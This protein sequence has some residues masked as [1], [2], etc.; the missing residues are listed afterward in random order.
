MVQEASRFPAT[1]TGDVAEF[2]PKNV[3][4]CWGLLVQFLSSPEYLDGPWAAKT[5]G[6]QETKVR[7]RVRE[8]DGY[9]LGFWVREGDG[10][11]GEREKM[12]NGLGHGEDW[13]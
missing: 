7:V 5:P 2:T 3:A 6:L 9:G 1:G 12:G 13:A 8:G 11:R 10:C 4:Q